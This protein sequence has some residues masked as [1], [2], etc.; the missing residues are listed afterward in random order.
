MAFDYAVIAVTVLEMLAE[1][2]APAELVSKSSTYDPATGT[3]SGS[4]ETTPCTACVITSEK[5]YVDGTL[6]LAGHRVALL[7][8]QG[9]SEPKP[10]MKLRWMG[11]DL[12]VAVCKP[13]APAGV[14]VLYELQVKQ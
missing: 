8:P 2:G 3:A 11:E 12:T 13:L 10:G 6:I 9:I 14:P 1:F 4:T 5:S 7:P